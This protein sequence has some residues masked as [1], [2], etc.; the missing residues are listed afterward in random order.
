MKDKYINLI[1]EQCHH[2]ENIYSIFKDKKPIIEYL[3]NSEEILSYPAIDYINT[4]SDRTREQTKKQYIDTC[5]NNQF[6]LFVKD[7]QNQKL[8]SYILDIPQD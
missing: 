4:L 8:K 1:N 2:I 5:N 3:V 6:L 7:V